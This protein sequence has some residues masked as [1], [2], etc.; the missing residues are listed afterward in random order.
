[1]PPKK[2]GSAVEKLQALANGVIVRAD[3]QPEQAFRRTA[4]GD[5]QLIDGETLIEA[6]DFGIG[7]QAVVEMPGDSRD[8][9]AGIEH[10]YRVEIEAFGFGCTS[11]RRDAPIPA[12]KRVWCHRE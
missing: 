5:A 11:V 10:A 4:Y 12:Q 2:L 6:V 3:I 7:A 9:P 1:M 8:V